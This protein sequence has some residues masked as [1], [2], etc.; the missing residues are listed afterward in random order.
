MSPDLFEKKDLQPHKRRRTSTVNGP[1]SN[2]KQFM[3]NRRIQA[4]PPI[5]RLRNNDFDFVKSS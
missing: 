4:R 3:K 1:V 5:Q 2:E